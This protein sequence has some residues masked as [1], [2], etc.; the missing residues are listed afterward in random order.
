MKRLFLA[1]AGLLSLVAAPAAAAVVTATPA[2][3]D[4]AWVAAGCGDT[5]T[6]GA[7]D[8]GP[9]V[10]AP[11]A[12][13]AKPVVI[14]AKAATTLTAWTAK[15]VSG[16]ELRDG[17]LRSVGGGAALTFEGSKLAD[18][19]PGADC[20]N[21]TVLRARAVG[22]FR[23]VPGEPFVAGDGYGV[24]FSRCQDVAVQDSSFTGFKVG[25][26]FGQ[27]SRAAAIGN[28]CAMMR[29]DCI[30]FGQ[31]W[32]GR[33]ERNVCHA[34]I[35]TGGEHPD[36]VQAY[37]RPFYPNSTTAAPPTSDLVIAGNVCVGLMQC[38]FL[39][40]HSRAYPDGVTRDDGG[41]DRVRV[42]GN[43]GV[44]GGGSAIGLIG[45]RGLILRGNEVRTLAGAPYLANINVKPSAAPEG[46]ALT[47]AAPTD[48]RCGNVVA[49]GAGKAGV[50]EPPCER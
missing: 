45:V 44:M 30:N 46:D 8:Y 49:A 50:A 22:P 31:V 47:L 11:K 10:L 3:F 15:R 37:S 14:N 16:L 34:T 6:L 26:L 38:Y 5:I 32:G 27:T 17:P 42:E 24:G 19:S 40:N 21:I 23:A 2:T 33:A 41:F 35:I 43:L 36:C 39:G 18:G 9:R 25:I 28:A 48:V 4:A 29:S 1:L 12:C 13:A 20:R 7:G